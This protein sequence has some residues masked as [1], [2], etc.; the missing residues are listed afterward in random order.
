MLFLY[1]NH[2]TKSR[3]NKEMK[4]KNKTQ[5]YYLKHIGNSNITMACLNWP[6]EARHLTAHE[7]EV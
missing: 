4:E 3:K 6:F 7:F 1:V 5:L 2:G